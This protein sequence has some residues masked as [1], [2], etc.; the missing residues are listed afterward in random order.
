MKHL[1]FLFFIVTIFISSCRNNI[2]NKKDL[3]LD[4]E[5]IDATNLSSP[6]PPP[7]ALSQR[8]N[9]RDNVVEEDKVSD[10]KH[11]SYNPKLI[12]KGDLT[13]S[14][15]NIENTKSLIYNFVKRCNGQVMYESLVSN[16]PYT[17]YQISLNIE[18]SY[19][20]KFFKLIDSSKLNI[21]AKSLTAED[22]TMEYIDN[23]TRLEN[24]KKLEKRYLEL[25]TRT[26]DIK[27]MLDI[28]EKLENIR[29]DIESRERQ[30]KVMEKQI[31][32][33][34]IQLRIEKHA[35]SLNYEDKNRYSRKIL[36]GFER[37][38]QAIKSIIVFLLSIWP[39]Y[40]LVLIVYLLIKYFR[41][42]KNKVE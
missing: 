32:Y 36:E 1:I 34:D 40:I 41:K 33:S 17:C 5:K 11:E 42:Q 2:S 18:A 29:S 3:S 31:A 38:W 7:P 26:T 30:L 24:K 27:D 21:I 39:L 13:I 12:K 28:E 23:S 10:R 20:D 25:L 6:P 4:M 19:F 22:V 15:T 16:D 9:S 35:V 8:Y 14:S 37:G